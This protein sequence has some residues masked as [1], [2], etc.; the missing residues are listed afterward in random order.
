MTL[1]SRRSMRRVS[2]VINQADEDRLLS[3][4]G[5]ENG[6][7]ACL[8]TEPA[9][10]VDAAIKLKPEDFCEEE[11]KYLFSIMLAIYNKK[12]GKNC[13]YDITTLRS[14]AKESGKE[15][16]FLAKTGKEYVEYLNLV[17]KS[18]VRLEMFESY[19]D[20]V[21][22]LSVKRKL[23]RKNEEFKRTILESD[24]SPEELMTQERAEIDNLF[25]TTAN[26]GNKLENL[27]DG[28]LGFIEDVMVQKRPIL[29][30]PTKFPVLDKT[31]EGLKRKNLIII[32]AHKKTGKTAFLMNIGVNVGVY[33]QIPTL[34]ISTEM[35]NREIMS[36][37]MA[38]LSQLKEVDILKGNVTTTPDKNK[39]LEAEK[40]FKEGKLYHAEMRGF[41]VEKVV[42]LVR[43]FVNN[44]VGYDDSGKV[45]DCLVIFDYIK[46]P[47]STSEAM[48]DKEYKV[49][50]MMADS[51]K[52]LAGDLD[53]PILTA[54]QTNRSGEI[55]N[56]YEITWF[57]NTFC[58]L[59]KKTDKE[60]E[61]DKMNGVITGNQRL[62]IMDNR[63]GTTNEDGINFDYDGSR[64]TYIEIGNA[65]KQTN[66]Y[67]PN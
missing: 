10:M 33:Q 42:A 64:L 61:K 51:L 2:R 37:V 60:L 9:K 41:T 40:K 20:R 48:R 5:T 16:D 8:M 57:C 31:I 46:M 34:M 66:Q 59:Q 29:G 63:G 27:G 17:Q 24:K 30:I 55:A 21:A 53:I 28:A 32:S 47:S 50:G 23:Y 44:T 22:S 14:I 1:E 4:P 58:I 54:C 43:K 36:R 3:D 35:S 39:L 26:H 67:S 13:H 62:K 19:T 11:A 15:E 65:E 6:I 52:E 25:V 12:N 38:N 49:L 7:L 18:M 45:K 56:S